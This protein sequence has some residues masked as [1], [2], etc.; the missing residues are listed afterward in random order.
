MTGWIAFGVLSAVLVTSALAVVTGKDLVRSVLYLAI[1]LITTAVVYAGLEA[2]FLAAVQVLLYT[3]GIITLMLF[4][5]ML[6]QRLSGARIEHRS[7]GFARAGG[8]A[9]G[10]LFLLGAGIFQRWSQ[11]ETV[12]EMTADSQALGAL[13][14]TDLMLP[15]E[16]L[17]ILLLAAMVGAIA[18]ARRKDP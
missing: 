6:T 3:G 1:T 14:L 4:A 13:F 9:L 17:S 2:D 11:P 8:A 16:L 12:I 18:L 10:V 15:F 7:D 5:V